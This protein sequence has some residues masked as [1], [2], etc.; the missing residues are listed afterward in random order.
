MGI[1]SLLENFF[2]G[3]FMVICVLIDSLNAMRQTKIAAGEKDV[4]DGGAA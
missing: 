1:P 2:I 4:Q 3:F